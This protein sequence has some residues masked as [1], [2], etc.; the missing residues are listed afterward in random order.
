M[1]DA[2]L[3]GR[4]SRELDAPRFDDLAA[5][6][7]R[8]IRRHRVTSRALAL[9]LTTLVVGS[10]V[11]AV[12]RYQGQRAP[13]IGAA[14]PEGWIAFT[15]RENDGWHVATVA[16][17]GSGRTVLTDGVRDYSTS[18]SPDGASIVFDR[19]Y[20][21]GRGLWVID[22]DGTD[23]RRLTR[24]EDFYGRWSPD[25]STILFG[26]FADRMVP[27]DEFTKIAGQNLW[28]VG[29]DGSGERQLTTARAYDVPGGW[30]PDGSA[31]AFLRASIDGSGIW[32]INDDGTGENEVVHFGSDGGEEASVQVDGTPVW[33]PDGSTLLYPHADS[34]WAVSLDGSD[35]RILIEGATDPAY[36]PDGSWIAFS[37]DAD[38][39]IARADGTE[40]RPI[41]SSPEEEIQPSWGIL[42]MD[43]TGN[44]LTCGSVAAQHIDAEPNYSA[45]Y[46]ER[47]QT[48]DGCDVRLDYVMTRVEA[49]I[50]DVDE[51]LIGWP[52]GQPHTDRYRIFLRDPTGMTA[53]HVA[54]DPNAAVPAAA[55][56]SGLRWRG[57][58]LWLIPDR[59]DAVWLKAADHVER[60]PVEDPLF[61]CD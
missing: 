20:E 38:I 25:G 4:L 37:R 22:A 43:P 16:P 49:C 9:V 3:L 41:T 12:A 39:W 8:E 19:D 15:V 46:I 17:D 28:I 21:E 57:Y 45:R 54:F 36:S 13:F 32:T 48:A 18:W 5:R 24:G 2:D 42:A 7:E 30:S 33:S 23:P 47:W 35:A 29:A 60:W 14:A 10:L 1:P 44:A 56:E 58:E 53:N 52:V 6:R 34:I 26:R 40:E 51:L 50:R 27:V 31:M 11:A 59:D 61:N 55:T